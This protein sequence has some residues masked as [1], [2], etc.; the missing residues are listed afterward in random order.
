MKKYNSYH[1]NFKLRVHTGTISFEELKKIP[2]STLYRFR[3][4]NAAYFDG[5]ISSQEN[6]CNA[7]HDHDQEEFDFMNKALVTYASKE[8]FKA[9]VIVKSTIINLYLMSGIKFNAKSLQAKKKIVNVISKVRD[10]IGFE[11]T[12]QYFDITRQTFYSWYKQVSYHC[13]HSTINKCLKTWSLQLSSPE[14]SALIEVF[15]EKIKLHW[16]LAA[17]WGYAFSQKLISF[18]LSTFMRHVKLLG[19]NKEIMRVK[20]PKRIGLRTSSPNEV[21]H[22]D[23][24]VCIIANHVKLYLY[25]LIDNF[26]K[27]ILSWKVSDK[28]SS[29]IRKNTI[30]EAYDKYHKQANKIVYSDLSAFLTNKNLLQEN[31]DLMTDG[32]VENFGEL[33]KYLAS[34]AVHLTKIIAQK[35]T[36]YSNSAIEAIN[37]ILKYET[38]FLHDLNSQ[39]DLEKLLD[40]AIPIYN[41]E[42]PNKSGNYLL[43]PKQVYNGQI[44]RKEEVKERMNE[45]KRERILYNKTHLCDIC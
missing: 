45:A 8:L 39:N 14:I 10:I 43:T 40:I 3:N 19:L 26:S 12:L 21:W 2:K 29:K 44:V 23:I 41:N 28:V 37:K 20:K 13:Q 32:G 27:Y 38:I 42:R 17:I 36:D 30:K 34:P 35:D 6:N 15:K 33:D 11:R 24:T 25:L 7:Y 5:I 1:T 9:C 4:L 16:P 22:A 31:I 18:S